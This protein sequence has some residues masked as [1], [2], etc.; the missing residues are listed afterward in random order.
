M[1]QGAAMLEP[2]PNDDPHMLTPYGTI[3]CR[4][5]HVVRAVRLDL[6]YV[7][8]TDAERVRCEACRAILD[9]AAAGRS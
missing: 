8:T 9:R 3:L 7:V 5:I 2:A 6:G 1:S 4:G